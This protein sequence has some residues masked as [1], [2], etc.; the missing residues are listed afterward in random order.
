M[1]GFLQ[2]EGLVILRQMSNTLWLDSSGP[3]C[4]VGLRTGEREFCES[5]YLNRAH[6]QRMLGLLDGIL[7]SAGLE[8]D[9]LDA[10]G[11]AC[12]PGSFTGVRMAAATVQALCSVANC[13]TVP[14]PTNRALYLSAPQSESVLVAIKSRANAFYVSAW[15]QQGDEVESNLLCDTPPE[16]LIQYAQDAVLMGEQ[17]D[18]W[19]N[20]ETVVHLAHADPII[21]VNTVTER[22]HAG[23]ALSP[24]QALPLYF[25]GDSPWRPIGK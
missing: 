19:P 6:N 25:S 5:H 24:E 2:V 17:P 15:N 13:P 12:G 18:W 11:F 4:N 22:L 16:W 7:K 10:I 14:V 1:K 8:P 9:E 20:S 21:L 23:E 3:Y